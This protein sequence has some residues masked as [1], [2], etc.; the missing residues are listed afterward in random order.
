L[1]EG[2]NGSCRLG[3]KVRTELQDATAGG[4]HGDVE[5][6]RGGFVEEENHAVQFSIAR[7]PGER[8][9]ERMKKIAPSQLVS[10][11]HSR[12]EILETVGIE[13]CGI[14]QEKSSLTDY[15]AR[16]KASEHGVC[17]YGLKNLSRVIAENQFEKF[18]KAC[19]IGG[20]GTKKGSGAFAEC[21]M[22][23]RGIS[24]K[25]TTLVKKVENMFRS[26]EILS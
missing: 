10:F 4:F 14:K 25:P 19:G 18:A 15:V 12:H 22:F 9:P 1:R 6:K 24:N 17:F 21:E 11:F 5:G 7:P 20:V 8:K 13:R 23:R 26:K 2:R 3:I 16:G